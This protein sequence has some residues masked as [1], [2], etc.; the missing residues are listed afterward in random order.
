[1]RRGAGTDELAVDGVVG[2]EGIAS[3]SGP[4][5]SGASSDVVGIECCALDRGWL[6]KART[7]A[8]TT[9]MSAARHG[10]ATSAMTWN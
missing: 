1:L 8:P 4:A 9:K 6:T 10:V 5:G 3:F 2:I 7:E